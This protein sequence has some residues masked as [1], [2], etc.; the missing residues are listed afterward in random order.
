MVHRAKASLPMLFR[1]PGNET[2]L[3]EAQSIKAKLPIRV[4][5]SEMTILLMSFL[6]LYHGV[7]TS[8]MGSIL[9]IGPLP[10]MVSTLSEILHCKP[11]PHFPG[12]ATACWRKQTI[13]TAK[14]KHLL[15]VICFTFMM[16]RYIFLLYCRNNSSAVFF[17]A[18]PI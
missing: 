15:I 16:Q 10:V 11:F 4:T 3:S 17:M 5:P 18:C 2:S 6:L 13:S 1:L 7:K 12:C 9:S 8:P 14:K